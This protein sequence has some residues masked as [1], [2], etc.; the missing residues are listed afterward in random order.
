MPTMGDYFRAAGCQAYY[1][2]KWHVSHADIVRA[3]IHDA[4]ESYNDKGRP[5]RKII[6]HYR[7]ANRLDQY[8]FSGWIGPEPHG[9]LKANTGTNRDPA[10][11]KEAIELLYE[12]DAQHKKSRS[13]RTMAGIGSGTTLLK[14]LGMCL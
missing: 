4:L 7:H 5:I 1:K 3:G 10:F 6:D 12:L 11:A 14:K 13:A 2:G 8:G 9:K